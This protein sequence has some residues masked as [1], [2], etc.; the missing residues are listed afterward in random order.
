[1]TSAACRS[2]GLEGDRHARRRCKE[3]R[4]QTA[5][6]SDIGE[7]P[8]DARQHRAALSDG[9][10]LLDVRDSD[11]RSDTVPFR[12]IHP[13]DLVSADSARG[14][15]QTLASFE[16][17]S[18]NDPTSRN[19]IRHDLLDRNMPLNRLLMASAVFGLA[20]SGC[21]PQGHDSGG[22]ALVVSDAAQMSYGYTYHFTLPGD[23]VTQAQDRHIA[24][25]DQLGSA[26]CRMQEMHRNADTGSSGGST[27]FVLASG[28]A[29]KFGQD[30]IAPVTGLSGTMTS[31][32]FEAE[33]VSKQIADAQAKAGEKDNAA[34]RTTLADAQNRVA[35][36]AI[37]VYYDGKTA[38]GEQIGAAFGDAG[39]TM[40][41]SIIA[42]I[43]F[44]SAV[45]P[46]ALVFGVIFFVARAGIRRFRD[47]I[48]GGRR[49]AG[50]R[51]DR[52]RV[53]EAFAHD[54]SV[55]SD[56]RLS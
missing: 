25:C 30:L 23:A 41:S 20:L 16:N 51:Q 3:R 18:D 6:D 55:S 7:R 56:D 22:D 27:R 32:E 50:R 11:C 45:L 43:Y 1:M 5:R 39:E 19:R 14:T 40:R 24:M 46:W 13:F 2:R 31:R 44:L 49:H 35:T 54:P 52:N 21:S 4:H 47:M 48:P 42:L 38:F 8:T 12:A 17:D 36:S 37:W 9:K 28:D 29:Q 10:R 53:D 26:R 34:N 33:D 15:E